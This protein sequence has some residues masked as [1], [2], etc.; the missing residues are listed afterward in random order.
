ML[1]KYW[2]MEMF[3]EILGAIAGFMGI[4]RVRHD[5]EPETG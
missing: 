1:W 3:S 5:R 4:L 2:V